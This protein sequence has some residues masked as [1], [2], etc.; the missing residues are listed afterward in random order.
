M[1]SFNIVLPSAVRVPELF[2][3][4]RRSEGE[5]DAIVAEELCKLEKE[6]T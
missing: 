1:T 3:T 5:S 4:D 2:Y 6:R